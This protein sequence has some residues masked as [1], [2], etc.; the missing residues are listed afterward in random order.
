MISKYWRHF[1]RRIFKDNEKAEE[2]R[3]KHNYENE[4]YQVFICLGPLILTCGVGTMMGFSGIFLPQFRNNISFQTTDDTEIDSW[5]ASSA[6]IPMGVTALL[7]GILM[8]KIGRKWTHLLSSIPGFVGWIMIS[9]S[10]NIS[11]VLLGRL[12]TGIACG[13]ISPV[14]S[15]Y[16]GETTSP[17]LR[18]LVSGGIALSVTLGTLL[19]HCVGSF[20]TWRMTAVFCSVF[21]ALGSLLT[22]FSPESPIWL[23]GK[24]KIDEGCEIFGKIRGSSESSTIELN[25]ALKRRK[26]IREGIENETQGYT[27]PAKNLMKT[28]YFKPFIILVLYFVSAQ[29]SGTNVVT[30]YAINVV[31]R[32]LGKNFE[33]KYI[34]MLAMDSIRVFTSI[35]S[36]ILLKKMPRR[37]IAIS[38]GAGCFM[39]LIILSSSSYFSYNYSN[40]TVLVYIPLLALLGYV[41]FV[42]I[43]LVALP[44]CLSGELLPREVKGLASGTLCFISFTVFFIVIKFAP[45]LYVGLGT[46]FTYLIFSS[47]A[48]FGTILCYCFLP[49]TKNKTLDN[50]AELFENKN[51]EIIIT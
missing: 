51:N 49:E 24:N 10:S 20:T 23:I 44:W 40:F 26:I 8:D 46:H 19:C 22:F 25:D 2:E 32:S 43:A 47:S 17:S 14:T 21:P 42:S 39:C 1:K 27:L 36:C 33:K 50:I 41:F 31:E 11:M 13:I 3:K 38:G 28:E 29:V 5:I 15:V 9:Y 35:V 45:Q 6:V 16:I 18:P 30:F 34:V 4:F 37:L 48:L 7:G 12:M